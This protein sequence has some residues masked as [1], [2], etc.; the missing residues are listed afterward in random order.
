MLLPDAEPSD[1]FPVAGDV[2]LLEIIQ[3]PPALADHFQQAAAGVVVFL[4]GLEVLL[5]VLDPLA[6]QGDLNLR[7]AGVRLLPGSG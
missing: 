1:Y 2:F 5:Q 4:V 7:G 3:K 6:Q